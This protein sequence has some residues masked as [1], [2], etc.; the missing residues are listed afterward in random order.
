[1]KVVSKLLLLVLVFFL[2]GCNGRLGPLAKEL[3]NYD[4]SFYNPPR[5]NHGPGWTFRFVKTHDGKTVTQT[6][7]ENL[8][9]DIQTLDGSLSLPAIKDK[10]T[11]AID[12]SVNLLDGLI[13]NV[14]EAK[15]NLS[16]NKIQEISIK[17]GPVTSKEIPLER[18]FDK[19]GKVVPIS[20]RCHATLLDLKNRGEL[21]NSIFVV[22]EAA[23]VNSLVYDAKVDSS[24][25]GSV[26][27]SFKKLLE[28]TPKAKVTEN[29]QT[30]L[31]IE[32]SR[33]VGYRAVA[34]MEFVPT[35]L[36]GPETATVKGKIVP[37]EQLIKIAAD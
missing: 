10:E 21:E 7:C 14:G 1:M 32:A 12:F 15:L 16:N 20:P 13:K 2:V 11:R 34:L 17:W 37:R 29:N 24:I 36:L 33:Y 8:Y 26:N 22:Q 23:I 28:F 18:R 35:N 25:Q 19:N 3:S 31:V 5:S 27:F 9:P 6:V 30:S 4:Y